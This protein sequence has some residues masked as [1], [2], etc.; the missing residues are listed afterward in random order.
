M[1]PPSK[2]SI[3]DGPGG[4]AAACA[5]ITFAGLGHG[6][7]ASFDPA[8]AAVLQA[9]DPYHSPNRP[10]SLPGAGAIAS[11]PTYCGPQKR[12][13][14]G[15]GGATSAVEVTS[16]VLLALHVDKTR[17]TTNHV[18][19]LFCIYGNV[20]RVKFLKAKDGLMVEYRLVH[21]TCTL[22]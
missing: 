19:N 5:A 6:D 15:L 3:L 8:M 20:L 14:L 12:A 11:G 4:V 21:Y 10:P 17:L 13:S 2:T 9:F 1:T 7:P 22:T 18:F 16:P